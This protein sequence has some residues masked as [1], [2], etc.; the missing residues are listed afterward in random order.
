MVR[1]ESTLVAEFKPRLS[2]R[3]R[4]ETRFSQRVV[5]LV[6]APLKAQERKKQYAA[7]AELNDH[8]L[9]DIGLRRS[10]IKIWNL[11]Q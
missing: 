10:A 2:A 5:K 11:K 6:S 7:L 1:K 3:H 8:T 9:A 4:T